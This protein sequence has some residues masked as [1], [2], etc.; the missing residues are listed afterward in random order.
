[1]DAITDRIWPEGLT[2]VPYWVY[3]RRRLLALEQ[4][5]MFEGPAWNFLCL[6]AELANTG[7]YRT[8]FVGDMPVVVARAEDGEIYAS[9]TAAPIAAR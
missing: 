4:K 8:T 5:R 2:R 1:M 7:D 3:T 6:E 9:R